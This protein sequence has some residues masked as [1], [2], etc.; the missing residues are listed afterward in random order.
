MYDLFIKRDCT[1]IEVNPLAETPD[2]RGTS[3]LLTLP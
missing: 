2:G 1:L 3:K